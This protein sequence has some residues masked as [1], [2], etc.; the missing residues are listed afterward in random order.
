M[1]VKDASPNVALNPKHKDGVL[2][3]APRLPAGPVAP[4][5]PVGPLLPSSP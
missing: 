2:T 3:L 4:I 1:G 5:S